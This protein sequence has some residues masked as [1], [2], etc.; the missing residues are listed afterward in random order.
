MATVQEITR[1]SHRSTGHDVIYILPVVLVGVFLSAVLNRLFVLS[2]N[3][4]FLPASLIMTNEFLTQNDRKLLFGANSRL[5]RKCRPVPRLKRSAP[6][7]PGVTRRVADNAIRPT[8]I[9]RVFRPAASSWIAPPAPIG[10]GGDCITGK[11]DIIF[12]CSLK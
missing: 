9:Y 7:V 8:L 2:D 5:D 12:Q 11:R 3:Q 10:S 1:V 4:Q 6:S